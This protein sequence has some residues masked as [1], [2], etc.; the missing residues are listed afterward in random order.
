MQIVGIGA[1]TALMLLGEIGGAQ[2]FA[3]ASQLVS[4][5]GL[6]PGLDQSDGPARSGLPVS[7][8]GRRPL[9]WLL[10]EAAWTHVRHGGPEASHYHR[11]VK[12]GKP[13]GVAIVALA[14]RLLVRVWILLMRNEPD[15]QLQVARYEQKLARLA[16]HRQWTGEPQPMNRDWAAQQLERLTGAVSPCGE[17]MRARSVPRWRSRPRSGSQRAQPAGERP[18][19]SE[20]R[21]E[22]PALKGSDPSQRASLTAGAG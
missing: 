2:R 8:A 7:K 22:F 13:E 4:Y 3:H 1:E 5:A 6:D 17:Q 11:L 21:S 15:R 10:V 9:R 20:A 12:R 18:T 16:G 14:R 19:A